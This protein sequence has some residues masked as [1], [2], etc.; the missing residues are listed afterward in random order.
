MNKTDLLRELEKLSD[1]YSR[2]EKMLFYTA[3]SNAALHMSDTI[4]PAPLV[5]ALGIANEQLG[6]LIHVLGKEKVVE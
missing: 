1:T 4:R 2:V 6:N 3:Q 5:S